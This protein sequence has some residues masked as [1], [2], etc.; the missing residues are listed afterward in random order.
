VKQKMSNR[1]VQRR[2]CV[3]GW[4][5]PNKSRE[6]LI[7]KGFGIR[8]GD[9]SVLWHCGQHAPV[10]VLAAMEGVPKFTTAKLEE[11]E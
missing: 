2:C 8:K 4:I 1:D 5:L 10:E 6:Y 7:D 3:C 9:G 11:K